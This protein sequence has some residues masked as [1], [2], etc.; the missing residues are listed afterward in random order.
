MAGSARPMTRAFRKRMLRNAAFVFAVLAATLLILVG[1]LSRRYF[2][3][4]ALVLI[5]SATIALN[6]LQRRTYAAYQQHLKR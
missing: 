6:L 4:A 1:T 3:I 2:A 5:P